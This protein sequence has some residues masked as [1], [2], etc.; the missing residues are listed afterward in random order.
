MD[1]SNCKSVRVAFGGV[2]PNATRSPGAEA[3]LTGSSLNDSA[4]DAAAS[5]LANDIAG[6]AMGDI[7]ASA[8]Y[9][10]AMAGVYLKRAVNAALG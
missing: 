7:Y 2:T 10:T 1:G 3:A 9:R 4:L 6:N 5:A 8:D